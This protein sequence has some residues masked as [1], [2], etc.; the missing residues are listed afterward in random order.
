MRPV[1]PA[2]PMRAVMFASLIDCWRDVRDVVEVARI[3]VRA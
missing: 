2:M 1:M 3:L